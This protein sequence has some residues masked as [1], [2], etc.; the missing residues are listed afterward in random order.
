[1]NWLN[2]HTSILDS[3]QVVGAEPTDRA[4]WLF[5][6]RYCIGQENGGRITDA[7]DWKDRKWQQLVRITLDEAKRE[8]G[9]WEWSGA[10][11]IVALYPSE[12]ELEVRQLRSIGGSKTE[13][14]ANAARNNGANGGRPKTQHKTQRENPT[15][16]QQEPNKKPIEE[17]RIEGEGEGEK[18]ENARESASPTMGEFVIHFAG[19]LADLGEPVRLDDWLKDEWSYRDSN[20]QMD[21]KRWTSLGGTLAAKYRAR[22]AEM[23]GRAPAAASEVKMHYLP[24]AGMVPVKTQT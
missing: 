11:L 22:H 1:M 17:K 24:G 8:S 23:K 10:D 7:A 15:G 20:R 12:K 19:Q 2:L 9:L 16:T 14:K 3:E 5:L 21:G 13:R 4:T 18:K 6:L